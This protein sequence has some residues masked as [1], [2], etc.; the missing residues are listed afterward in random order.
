MLRSRMVARRE[1]RAAV[2][3]GAIVLAAACTNQVSPIPSPARYVDA[4][5]E[6]GGTV[7]PDASSPPLSA[8]G[9]SNDGGTCDAAGNP[10]APLAP[11][12]A[13]CNRAFGDHGEQAATAVNVDRDGNI[14]IAG[15]MEGAVDFGG[16]PVS[17]SSAKAMFVARYDRACAHQWTKTFAGQGAVVLDRAGGSLVRGS[18]TTVRLDA[19]GATVW[20]GGGDLDPFGN[21]RVAIDPT[22]GAAVIWPLTVDSRGGGGGGQ[23]NPG[24][25]TRLDGNG[26]IVWTTPV[27][28]ELKV[29]PVAIDPDGNVI[30]ARK[31]ISSPQKPRGA[32]S[33]AAPRRTCPRRTVSRPAARSSAPSAARRGISFACSAGPGN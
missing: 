6:E 2:A 8:C 11:D 22:G 4:G 25:I 10:H 30:A 14:T 1:H 28:N 19:S 24:G 23:V 9:V 17:Q 16:G 33:S 27:P 12:L 20:Q 29:G 32:S 3:L 7:A 31:P 26:K 13:F 18:P 15:S 21:R 5:A